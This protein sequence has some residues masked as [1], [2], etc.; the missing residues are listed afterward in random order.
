MASIHAYDEIKNFL[1]AQFPALEVLDY[2]VIRDD[3]VQAEDPFIVLEERSA[4]EDIEAF[5]DPSSLCQREVGI[6]LAHY[7]TPSPES[8]AVARAGA[9]SIQDALRHRSM[10]GVRVLSVSPPDVT[11]SNDGNWTI[12]F[13]AVS[14][15]YD[16]NVAIP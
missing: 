7:Y 8:L 5:G 10:N 3:K 12:G 11:D 4:A 16:F 6:I 9:G 15:Q 14:Y 2:D 1:V 13:V